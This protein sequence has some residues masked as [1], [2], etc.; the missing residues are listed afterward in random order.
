MKPQQQ[1]QFTRPEKKNEKL[2]KQ[3]KVYNMLQ[4]EKRRAESRKKPAA[5]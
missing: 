5:A 1:Q 3:E 2:T 4:R